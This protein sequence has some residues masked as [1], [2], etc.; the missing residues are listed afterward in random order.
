MYLSQYLLGLKSGAVI[1][2]DIIETLTGTLFT[3]PDP[4]FPALTYSSVSFPKYQY[5]YVRWAYKGMCFGIMKPTYELLST[6]FSGCHLAR[7]TDSGTLYG[8]HIHCEKGVPGDQRATWNNYVR[9]LEKQSVTIFQP[10]YR[11][12]EAHER[13]GC[14]AVDLWGIIT[15]DRRCYSVLVELLG[16]DPTYPAPY[17]YNSREIKRPTARL[18]EIKSEHP[19]PAHDLFI[20]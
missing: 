18:V 3:Q 20:H 19:K 5:S 1:D 7:F 9:A 12:R 2:P 14:K 16:N 6:Q 8:C 17:F 13:D 4:R 11:L 15:P 10:D